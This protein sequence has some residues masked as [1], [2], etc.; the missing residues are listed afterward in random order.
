MGLL[1]PARGSGERRRYGRD[2]LA[3]VAMILRAKEAGFKLEDIHEMFAARAP[4]ARREVLRRHRAGLVR[5]IAEARASLA[6]IDCALGCEH[7][8]LTTCGRFQ[9]LIA[10]RV[11]AGASSDARLDGPVA[12]RP[13]DGIRCR[14]E[15]A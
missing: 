7:E 14:S 1:A 13:A 2:D 10:D 3:R 6:L 11:D 8:D 5:R 12:P 15:G 4:D 9:A